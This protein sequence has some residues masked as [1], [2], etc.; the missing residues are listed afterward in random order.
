[1]KKISIKDVV[2]FRRKSDR[3]KKSFAAAI[4]LNKVKISLEGGGDYWITSLSAISNSY[5][6]NDLKFIVD[7]RSELEEKHDNTNYKQTKT[8][9][10]RNIDILHNYE[11]F[12]LKKWRPAKK[13]RLLKKHKEDSVLTIRGLEVHVAPHHVFTFTRNEE[14]E[15][16][17]IWYIAQLDG[18][19]KEELGM[20]ADILFRYLKAHYSK[21]YTLNTKYCIA[22][23]VFNNFEVSYSQLENGDIPLILN[24]TLDEIKRL[25]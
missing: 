3:S 13:M 25:M 21:E 19:R 7:K 14:N 22:I 2:A 23:D 5:K 18:F 15:V 17:A 9:Y 10:K 11:N 20:F 4:K 16:G 1:M 6:L 24:S 12:D 8:M